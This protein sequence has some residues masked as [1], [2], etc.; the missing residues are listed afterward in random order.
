M[1]NIQRKEDCC[2]CGACYDACTQSAI[3]WETDDEGEYL[4]FEVTFKVN[5]PVT[6]ITL[7]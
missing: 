6:D 5:D 2:G 1:I 3:I 7:R 4:I